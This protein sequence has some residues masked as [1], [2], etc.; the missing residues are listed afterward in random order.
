MNKTSKYSGSLSLG[1]EG[2]KS[3]FGCKADDDVDSIE[4]PEK[5]NAA[6]EDEFCVK[7][8]PKSNKMSQPQGLLLLDK[9]AGKTSFHLVAVLRKLTDIQKIGHAGTLDPFA[10]GVM[11]MLIGKNFTR[12]AQNLQNYDKS[13][14]TTLHLGI[15]TDSYDIDGKQVN[16]SDLI[17]TLDQIQQALHDFQ[18]TIMQMPPMF[19]AKKQGGKKLYELARQGITTKR[20]ARPVTVKT[21]LIDYA[22]PYLTLDID[23]TKGTY[24]RSIGHDLGQKLGCGA[25]LKELIRTRIGPYHLTDCIP[26][27]PKG[28]EFDYRE[29]IRCAL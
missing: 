10:T 21:T 22:Y 20:E 17:P 25:H 14:R 23:C 24:I 8:F 6:G 29:H 12:Q 1:K 4:S 11:V 13:Y 2:R 18:G 19:S 9:P 26:L 5:D 27:P 3:R 7:N 28:S 16:Q 15:E